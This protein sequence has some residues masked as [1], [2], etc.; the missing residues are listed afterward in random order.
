MLGIFSNSR[1]APILQHVD[2]IFKLKQHLPATLISGRL[3]PGNPSG[4]ICSNPFQCKLFLR[5]LATGADFNDQM[6]MLQGL[7]KQSNIRLGT[8]RTTESWSGLRC[9]QLWYD[10]LAMSWCSW[11]HWCEIELHIWPSNQ[12]PREHTYN[13][14]SQDNAANLLFQFTMNRPEFCPV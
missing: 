13:A 8:H 4:K 9:L 11:H 10:N 14:Y 6:E 1:H 12:P 2:E 3:Y 7:D 5:I